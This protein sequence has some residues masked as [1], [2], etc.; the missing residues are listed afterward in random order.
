MAEF[1]ILLDVWKKTNIVS[2][3]Y[4]YVLCAHWNIIKRRKKKKRNGKTQNE[5]KKNCA[6]KRTIVSNNSKDVGV[7]ENCR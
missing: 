2:S 3:S 1:R 4:D 6:I 7:D 5:Q